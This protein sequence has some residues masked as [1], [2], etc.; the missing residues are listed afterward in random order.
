MAE[1][2]D[3]IVLIK[4]QFEAGKGQVGKGGVVRDPEVHR[5]VLHDVLS[6]ASEAGYT[7]CGLIMSPLKGP[8]GNIE[9]L[10]WLC[11]QPSTSVGD[12]DAMITSALE[13][14]LQPDANEHD[15]V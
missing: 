2:A 6:A 14:T 4:P 9:F 10:A 8:A 3:L 13:G 12:I 5:R 1:R 15:G 11:T 7:P